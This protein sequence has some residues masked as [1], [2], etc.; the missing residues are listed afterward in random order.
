MAKEI[1]VLRVIWPGHTPNRLT[2]LA[3]TIYLEASDLLGTDG[4]IKLETAD[5]IGLSVEG[6]RSQSVAS[7]YRS[8]VGRL[9]A[10]VEKISSGQVESIG[11]HRAISLRL[12]DGRRI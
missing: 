9:R 3:D 4:P 10:D 8:I 5:R 11:A 7:R 12:L 2:A 1:H 6:L